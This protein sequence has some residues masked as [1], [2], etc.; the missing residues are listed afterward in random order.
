MSARLTDES[1]ISIPEMLIGM[2]VLLVVL[3][4]TLLTFTSFNQ[5]ALRNHRQNDSQEVARSTIVTLSRQ[6]RNL[7]G[8]AEGQPDAFDKI[9]A[10]DVVFKTVNPVGP[11]GAQNLSNVQRVRYCLDGLGGS[12]TQRVWRQVQTWTAAAPPAVPSTGS[13]PDSAWPSQEVV[14]TGIV[15]DRLGAGRPAFVFDSTDPTAVNEVR[16]D[17]FVDA[18]PTA[19][20]AE[21]RLQSGVYLRNQNRVPTASFQWSPGNPGHVILN[22]SASV[23]PEGQA[24]KFTWKDGGVKLASDTVVV[25]WSA[26]VGAHTVT[27]EVRDPQGLLS[28]QTQEVVIAGS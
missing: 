18:E 8:P 27:L 9:S 21:T 10:Y 14:A 23:D 1:G 5:T 13:C 22:A 19:S 17:L 12:G 26:S 7:A 24:L 11:P 16:T 25:D 28:S 6:L 3:A 4:A 2:S 20:P 15:N